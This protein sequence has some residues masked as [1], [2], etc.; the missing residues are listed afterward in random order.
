MAAAHV[1]RVSSTPI[2]ESPALAVRED[3]A[4]ITLSFGDGSIGTLHYFSNGHKSYPK[5]TLEVFCDGRALRLDNFRMLRGYGWS[6]F[7]K[8]KL[9][10]MDKGHGEEF[11]RFVEA[12]LRGGPSVIPFADIDNVMR[13]TFAAVDSARSGRPITPDAT[14]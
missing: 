6:G 1:V 2:G 10:R 8:M 13:A 7:S 14:G 9:T 5:E 3:K 11:R 4:T 12:A